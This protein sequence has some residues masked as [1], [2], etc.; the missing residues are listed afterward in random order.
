MKLKVTIKDKDGNV[1]GV[2]TTETD[3]EAVAVKE[4][5]SQANVKRSRWTTHR[6]EEVVDKKVRPARVG[7]YKAKEAGLLSD[8]NGFMRQGWE[9]S[10][11]ITE[12]ERTILTELWDMLSVHYDVE[13]GTG[14]VTCHELAEACNMSV[15]QINGAVSVLLAKELVSTV[16]GK[17]KDSGKSKPVRFILITKKGISAVEGN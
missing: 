6:I 4:A 2:T 5:Y 13:Y 1:L 7:T 3:D 9:G 12:K 17:I 16:R 15:N 10:S 14:E 11:V 8:R